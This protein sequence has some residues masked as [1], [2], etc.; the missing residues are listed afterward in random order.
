MK[1][2]KMDLDNKWIKL[3]SKMINWEWY[4]DQNTKSLFIHCL[5]KANWK[6]GNFEGMTIP[7][8]S[9]VTSLKTLSEELGMSVPKIRT[10]IKHLILT[11]EITI[12][13]TNKYRIITIKNY[14]LYQNVSKQNNNQL[15]NKT[16][17]NSNQIATIVDYIDDIDYIDNNLTTTTHACAST[18]NLYDFIEQT[19]GRTLSSAEFEVINT[20]EDSPLTRYAIK[21]AEISRVFNIKYIGRILA[22]YKRENIKTVTQAEE[23]DRRWQEKKNQKRQYH[24]TNRERLKEMIEEE[25]QKNE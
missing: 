1:W 24:Q 20:W 3:H 23:R 15:A 13:S 18:G 17:S 22:T 9:F 5:L 16:Q 7:R 25:R 2:C 4:K 12:K 11:N 14:E 6:V 19:F 21:Q 8:G 10:A